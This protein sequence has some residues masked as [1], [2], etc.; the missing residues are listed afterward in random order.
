VLAS[1][2]DRLDRFDLPGARAEAR[3]ASQTFSKLGDTT[4]A[5]QANRIVASLSFAFTAAGV[6]VLGLGLLALL[7]G[8]FV[9][10]R[11]RR[12]RI[13]PRSTLPGEESVSWL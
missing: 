6:A 1:A 4:R 8:G 2:Q 9:M 13:V 10:L 11:S 12:A 5:Q 7:G 3:F